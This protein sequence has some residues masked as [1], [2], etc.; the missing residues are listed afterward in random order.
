MTMKKINFL[1]L[2][3]LALLLFG[4]QAASAK[5]IT[6]DDNGLDCRKADFNTIQ[7]A[8]SAAAPGDTIKVCAGTYTEQVTIPAAKS[9]LTLRSHVPEAAIIKAPPVMADP[10]AIVRVNG[11]QDVT[12]YGFTIT[13]P[14]GSGCDSIRYGVRV[15]GGG[16]A[17][18]SHNHIV[19]IRDT[20]LSGCQNGNAIQIGRQFEGQTG[21]AT[22]T[23]NT[24]ERYQKTGVI[25][26]N[27]GSSAEIRNNKI[28]GLGQSPI[29]AQNGVQLSRG[30]TANVEH[31]DISG[32]VFTPGFATSTGVLLF[33]S[34]SVSVA[35]NVISTND[36]GIYS[37]DTS[38]PVI[39][40]NKISVSTYDGIDLIE[41]TGANVSYNFSEGA[42]DF[43]GIY[44]DSD[45]SGN[46]ISS[47]QMENNTEHDAHDDSDGPGT[48]GTAN[49]WEKNHCG[50]PTPENKPGLCEHIN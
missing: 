26:D 28:V 49:I 36:S 3:A 22:I 31:N 35:H 13:G 14:G 18:I 24:I 48:G 15:D 16:S 2:V 23:K 41:T 34:G 42:V 4:A 45:S 7:A 8:V 5:V 6:V 50:S 11:A 25:V 44:V 29:I 20:G 43:D 1:P 37:F 19:D 33:E 17:T 38:G 40:H 9:G 39:Q 27:A 10:K 32:N 12:I 47:N 46:T 30:A 21:H